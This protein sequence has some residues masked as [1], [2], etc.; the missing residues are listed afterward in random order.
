M[1]LF[2]ILNLSS[3]RIQDQNTRFTYSLDIQKDIKPY[4][5]ATLGFLISSKSSMGGY[6]W[7]GYVEE[8][9]LQR[10]FKQETV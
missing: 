3:M 5:A 4:E 2:N 7:W 9:K 1:Q 8:Y 10:H 6:D